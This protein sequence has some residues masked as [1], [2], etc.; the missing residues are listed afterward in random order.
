MMTPYEKLKLLHETLIFLKASFITEQLDKI[1]YAINDNEAARQ[2][3]EANHQLF[4]PSLNRIT[5]L[6]NLPTS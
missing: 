2:L 4:K 1:A 6:P 3:K 5:G